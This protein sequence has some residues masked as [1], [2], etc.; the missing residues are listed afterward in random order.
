V[1][2]EMNSSR[3]RETQHALNILMH[4][5]YL[6]RFEIFY[7]LIR[8]SFGPIFTEQR[9]G[10]VS[11]FKQFLPPVKFTITVPYVV[12]TVLGIQFYPVKTQ[13]KF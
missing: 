10:S 5:Y 11:H 1:A 8:V 13:Q 9:F 4:Y 3:G 6:I 7:G 2:K 12:K